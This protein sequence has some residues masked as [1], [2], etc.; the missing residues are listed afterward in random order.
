MKLYGYQQKI[1]DYIKQFNSFALFMEMGTGKTPVAIEL[2]KLRRV[3][4]LIVCPLTII[5][6]VWIKE[7]YKWAPDI[8]V[9]NS[10]DSFT[11]N[12]T[13][14]SCYVYVINY[15]M[16]RKYPP[17]FFKNFGMII[18]DESHKIKSVKSKISRF[19]RSVAKLFQYRLILTG[20][21]ASNTVLEFWPQMNF[22]EPSIL[23]PVVKHI[24]LFGPKK[25]VNPFNDTGY[26]QWRGRNF[27]TY[28]FGN[29]MWSINKIKKEEVMDEIR[30]R[31]IFLSKEDCLDLPGETTQ[32]YNFT[33]D[34]KTKGIYNQLKN[35]FIAQ[36]G[37]K[38][39]LASNKLAEI[40]K[41]RQITSGFFIDDKKEKVVFSDQ[42]FKVLE[43]VLEDIG[44]K[45]VIIWC[46]FHHEIN[47]IFEKLRHSAC[48]LY[49]E[50][51]DC[52]KELS[53]HSFQEGTKQYLIAH[54]QSGSLGLDFTNCNYDIFFSQS[55]SL[56]EYDQATSRTCR[57]GQKSKVT[58]IHINALDSIDQVIYKAVLK[59]QKV[60][61][62]LL[63]M[64][65]F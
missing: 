19:L 5:K 42:K 50:M 33:M 56:L 16:A 40:M 51:N 48:K 59:K 10:R 44:D 23:N 21:P 2:I 6:S 54:P 24:P 17:E 35:D 1:F 38:V 11:H 9:I 29:F 8:P 43:E 32:E 47:T 65:H 52:G 18:L 62:A 20:T 60:S 26:Y 46:Q 39:V 31:A 27:Q 57:N 34:N 53:I 63:E 37:N 55:Y 15:E 12:I 28:G 25:V 4:T 49:G 36:Y 30:Q 22:V 14:C 45:Q 58:H 64:L 61:D 13:P 7:L 41:L 3:K